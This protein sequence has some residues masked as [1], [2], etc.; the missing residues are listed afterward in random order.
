MDN[1][2]IQIVSWT[3]VFFS[4]GSYLLLNLQLVSSGNHVFLG[5]NILAAT[6]LGFVAYKRGLIA[7]TFQN[8]VW[9]AIT[10]IGYSQI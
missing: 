5:M 4:L 8:I 2:T 1:K 3:G 6:I 10:I 7:I 9:L